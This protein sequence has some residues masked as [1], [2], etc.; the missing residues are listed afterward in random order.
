[1]DKN[2]VIFYAFK[3]ACRYMREHPP[4]DAGW[5]GDMEIISC[6]VDGKNDPEGERWM[7]Y[8]INKVLDDMGVSK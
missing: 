4:C 2:E 3:K 7:L 6:V 5:E 8:F 1:M